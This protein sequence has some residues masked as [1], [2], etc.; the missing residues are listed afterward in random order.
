MVYR[1][2]KLCQ[3]LG[4]EPERAG[5]QVQGCLGQLARPPSISL[6]VVSYVSWAE[7]GG[8]YKEE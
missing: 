7:R 4:R 8:K 5:M 2:A 3:W 6:S 1:C